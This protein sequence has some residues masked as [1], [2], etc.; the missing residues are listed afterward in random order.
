MTMLISV[1]RR[2]RSALTDTNH[3]N[4]ERKLRDLAQ[5]LGCSLSSTYQAETGKHIEEELVR[6]IQEAAREERDSRLWI[7]ALISGI[8]SVLS[9]IVAIIAVT[10]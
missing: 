7:I 6:R 4:R 5:E 9:A 1:Q 2:L 3:N 10:R 8:A